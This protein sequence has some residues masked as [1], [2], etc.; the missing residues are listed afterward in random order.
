MTRLEG[1]VIM[2]YKK[3]VDVILIFF[4]E[5]RRSPIQSINME[6]VSNCERER[7]PV[8]TSEEDTLLPPS[9]ATNNKIYRNEP[10]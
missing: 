10:F 7:T 9:G 8:N 1:F 2:F 3:R 6:P 5:T 4:S